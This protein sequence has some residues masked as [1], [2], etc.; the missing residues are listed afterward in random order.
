MNQITALVTGADHV[1]GLGAARALEVAGA[2]VVGIAKRPWAPICRSRA[3]DSIHQSDEGSPEGYVER[4][5]RIAGTI[6]GPIFLLP[7]A[8]DHVAW[9]AQAREDMPENVRM[10]VP[11]LDTVTLLLEK[12]DFVE[13]AAKEGFP[14]PRSVVVNSPEELESALDGFPLPALLKPTVRTREWQM[15]SP[16]QKNIR[17]EK[18]AD[19][20][21]VPFDLF[22]TVPSYV[23]TEWIEGTDADVLFCL[24]YLD[25][26]SNILASFTGRKLLQYPPL[27]G[28]TAVCTDTTDPALETLTAELLQAARCTGLASLEVKRSRSDGRYLITEPTVGRPNMQSAVATSAGVN[29][30]GI[31]MRNT[32]GQDWSDLVSPRRRTLWVEESAFF[33]VVTTWKRPRLP[34]GLLFRELLSTRRVKGARFGFFDLGLIDAIVKRRLTSR[35]PPPSQGS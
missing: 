2:R 30:H 6:D 23:L 18:R 32:W 27:T 24:V 35:R 8:D 22:S 4:A 16:L 19:L 28:S 12:S 26:Q 15:A 33:D 10:A 11:P 14:I 9:F 3:W 29:L 13:W 25:D 17:M 5:I 34:Y 1:T 31:A 7:T 20:D 21:A